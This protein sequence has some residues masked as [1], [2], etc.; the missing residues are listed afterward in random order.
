MSFIP[1]SSGADL[2]AVLGGA[3]A[4]GL[5]LGWWVRRG[6]REE[7]EAS[8]PDEPGVSDPALSS[9]TG[10]LGPRNGASAV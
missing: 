10:E 1:A 5:G 6:D 9:T 4:A 7:A 3:L 2:M 8:D